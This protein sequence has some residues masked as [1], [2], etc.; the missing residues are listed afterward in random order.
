MGAPAVPYGRV[1]IVV[2]GLSV[3]LTGCSSMAA[4]GRRKGRLDVRGPVR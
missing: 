4:A 2:G 3:L 1:L